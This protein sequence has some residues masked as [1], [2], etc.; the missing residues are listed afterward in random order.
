MSYNCLDKTALL[1]RK[2]SII[3]E[4]KLQVITGGTS[5]M[6]LAAAKALSVYGPVLIGGRSEKR[7]ANALA[8]LKEAGVEAYGKPCDVSDKESLKA[9]AEYALTIAPIGNVINAAGVDYANMPKEPIIKINMLGTHYVLETFL[10]YLDDSYVVNFSSITGNFYPGPSKEE[11]ELWDATQTL[12]EE[13]FVKRQLE[14]TA[15]PMDPRMVALGDSYMTYA[16]SK[17]YVQYYTQANALRVAMKNNSR[18]I[19]IAPGSFYTPMLAEGNNEAM[20]ASIKRGT[21]YQ[22]FGTSEEMA[23]LIVHL[24][25][26]GHGYLTG[27]DIIHDGG[28]TA[29]SFAKQMM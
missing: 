6:G 19:S 11:K 22:R 18:I 8:E 20:Q 16:M 25:A 27:V 23:D 24:L 21:V 15:Q 2:E 5:G 13:E 3:M 26:P 29:L 12:S 17:R 7:L 14:L 28:K 9:F 10:P 4:R 1:S